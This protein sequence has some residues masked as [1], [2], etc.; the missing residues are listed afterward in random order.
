[1]AMINRQILDLAR[2]LVGRPLRLAADGAHTTLLLE[3][4]LVTVSVD[5]P[6]LPLAL[7][8]VVTVAKALGVQKVLALRDGA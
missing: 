6:R 4:F 1:M 3:H 2:R 5:A 7:L 8:D